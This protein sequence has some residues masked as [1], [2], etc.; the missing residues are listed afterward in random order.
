MFLDMNIVGVNMS[1]PFNGDQ[2]SPR[3]KFK[4]L[5]TAMIAHCLLPTP[6]CCGNYGTL[7]FLERMQC[8]IM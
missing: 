2:H 4:T 8:L 1:L 7:E 5:S 6:S 3:L